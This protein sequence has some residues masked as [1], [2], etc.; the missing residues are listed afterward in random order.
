MQ[1]KARLCSATACCCLS[2][3]SLAG[4]CF[5]LE[6]VAYSPG[7][8]PCRG[9]P[10]R[11]LA[12]TCWIL[13]SPHRLCCLAHYEASKKAC[14][15]GPMGLEKANCSH[16]DPRSYT[17]L[18][19]SALAEDAWPSEATSEQTAGVRG[20]RR[21]Q[22]ARSD[23]GLTSSVVTS[24]HP[25]PVQVPPTSPHRMSSCHMLCVLIC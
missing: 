2:L 10:A 14:S 23:G 15:F 11:V 19:D 25:R 4:F 24:R 13:L 12:L 6:R 17:R 1:H 7:A 8:T 22:V 3:P 20:S 21:A 9:C 16:T 5:A 18:Q